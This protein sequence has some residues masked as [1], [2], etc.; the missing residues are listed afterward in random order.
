MSYAYFRLKVPKLILL[1]PSN[2]II[3]CESDKKEKYLKRQVIEKAVGLL[4]YLHWKIINYHVLVVHN[5]F[6]FIMVLVKPPDFSDCDG[7]TKNGFS[8]VSKA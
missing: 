8:I 3:P 2:E 6:I 1:G 5:I 4:S 7:N